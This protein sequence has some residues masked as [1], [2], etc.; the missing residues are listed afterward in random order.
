MYDQLYRKR[1]STSLKKE[2]SR[3]TVEQ[4]IPGADNP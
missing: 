4:A 1:V 2:K 3:Q